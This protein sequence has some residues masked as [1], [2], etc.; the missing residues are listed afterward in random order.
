MKQINL[1]HVRI[2]GGTQSRVSIN[3]LAVADYAHAMDQ[4][5][6]LPPVTLFFDGAEYWLADGF[7][8]YHAHGKLGALSIDAEVRDGTPAD[9]K[10]FAFGANKDHGLRRTNKDKAKAVSGMLVDFADW[11]DNKIAKHVGVDH[12]TVAAHRVS[13][14]GNSQ[15]K[16]TTRT[17]E[18]NGKTYQ[19]KTKNIGKT[20]PSVDPSPTAPIEAAAPQ[21]PVDNGTPADGTEA[22]SSGTPEVPIEVNPLQAVL[23]AANTQIAE[24]A[25][26]LDET[27]EDNRRLRA[28]AD[29]EDRQVATMAEEIAKLRCQ[30]FE[31]ERATVAPDSPAESDGQGAVEPFTDPVTE[32]RTSITELAEEGEALPTT[33]GDDGPTEIAELRAGAESPTDD[34]V[35]AR[36]PIDLEALCNT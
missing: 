2:D 24:L 32:A 8:R 34:L 26:R 9:A 17:A 15:A 6:I 1:K 28:V 27:M 35:E 22:K 31:L 13:I 10:L 4:G 7:H 29:S 30:I 5:T 19:Q 18:R 20:K 16:T 36:E 11:C 33:A 14:L 23:D 3:A 21:E 12:K 25:R